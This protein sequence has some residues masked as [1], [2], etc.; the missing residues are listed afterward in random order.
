MSKLNDKIQDLAEKAKVTADKVARQV[1][2]ATD[3]AEDLAE[4]AG[5]KVNRAARKIDKLVD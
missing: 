2:Y 5:R 1:R 4:R 3:S